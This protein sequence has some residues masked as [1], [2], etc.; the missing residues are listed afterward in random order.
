M[1]KGK[2][3]NMSKESENFKIGV[4]NGVVTLC[5]DK[6]DLCVGIVQLTAGLLKQGFSAERIIDCVAIGVAYS[7]YANKEDN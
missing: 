4:E 7:K 5:G 1:Y 2:D 3:N 6:V